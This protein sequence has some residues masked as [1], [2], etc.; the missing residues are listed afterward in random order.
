MKEYKQLK[1]EIKQ[2]WSTFVKNENAYRREQGFSKIET[3]PTRFNV[4]E[5]VFNIVIKNH[6]NHIECID[7]LQVFWDKPWGSNV[8][9]KIV[10]SK[11]QFHHISTLIQYC[12]NKVFQI[13]N[14]FHIQ[15]ALHQ[16]EIQKLQVPKNFIRKL[17]GY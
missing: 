2:R 8:T 12:T 3:K 6:V 10:S 16:F 9:L 14:Q 15:D 1:D 5:R 13:H 11:Y 4:N 17:V 7:G